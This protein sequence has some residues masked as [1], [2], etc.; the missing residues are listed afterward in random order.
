MVKYFETLERWL[1][2]PKRRFAKPLSSNA[3][4]GSNPALSAFASSKLERARTSF[5]KLRRDTVRFHPP[6]LYRSRDS[7]VSYFAFQN[8]YIAFNFEI[9]LKS[10]LRRALMKKYNF[11]C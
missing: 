4:A 7:L 8:K 9:Y 5:L 6:K 11:M 3:R 2:G 1:S 10:C